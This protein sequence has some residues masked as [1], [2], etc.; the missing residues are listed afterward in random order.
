MGGYDARFQ[1]LVDA[2]LADLEASEAFGVS[3]AIMEGGEITFAQAFGSKDRQGDQP[4]TPE[5]LMQ[6]GSTTKQMTATA[7]LQKVE[8]GQLSL[9]DTLEELLPSLELAL[10]PT[11]DDEITARHLLT[12]QGA[13]YDFVEW[14]EQPADARLAELTYGQFADEIYLMAPPGS[15][16]N[17]ANPNFVMAGLV[18]EELDGR[19]WPDLMREDVFEPLGMTRTFA[20]KA[21]VE[22]DGD[23]SLSYGYT[24]LDVAQGGAPGP[25]IMSKVVDSGWLRPAGLVWTTPTQMM[26]WADFILRGNEDVLSDALRAEITEEQVDT[27]YLPGF[28]FYGHGMSVTRGFFD[29]ND[30]WYSLP[31]WHHD[32]N[33]LSFTSTFVM[34]P[35]Q[36]FAISIVTSGYATDFSASLETALLTLVDLPAPSAG[37]EYAIEPATFDRHV[38]SY[39]D[40]F[41]AGDMEITQVGDALNVSMPQLEQLGFDVAPELEA[42]TS[43]IFL[44]TIDGFQYDL[45]FI[46]SVPGQESTY[47]RNRIFVTTRVPAGPPP[48]PLPPS[49]SP[50]RAKVEA[51]LARARSERPLLRPRRPRHA[52]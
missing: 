34:L 44:V 1:P 18:T 36:D 42:I 6:I 33:T 12:H 41:Y 11:W 51:M 32:G 23:Y 31:L 25:L 17:Y 19:A 40:A 46:P 9:D 14:A 29:S 50:T 30:Q 52:R 43:D 47:V 38:G 16:F 35:E 28:D 21:E 13:F 5:T 7:L 22:A 27:A 45:T 3:V 8:S 26:R 10:G 24:E 20:R 15:F 48:M 4:L 49:A 37:P 2:L 39:H